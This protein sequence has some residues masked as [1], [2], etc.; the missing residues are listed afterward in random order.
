M[1]YGISIFSDLFAPQVDHL[2]NTLTELHH[3]FPGQVESTGLAGGVSQIDLESGESLHKQI[4]RFA[5]S[6]D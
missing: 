2:E 6:T 3:T 1:R 4:Q 5:V